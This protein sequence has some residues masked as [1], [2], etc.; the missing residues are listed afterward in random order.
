MRKILALTRGDVKNISRDP[1]LILSILGPLLLGLV[2]RFGLP[3]AADILRAET[4]FELTEHYDFIVSFLLLFTPMMLGILAGF[5]ILDERDDQILAYYAV[6]PL[7]KTGYFIYRTTAP[8]LMGFFFSF[9]LLALIPQVELNFLLLIPAILMASLQAPIFTLLLG[10][11]AENKVEGMALSKGLGII[12]LTPVVG[13]LVD[14]NWQLLA[15]VFPPYW[16]S[17]AFLASLGG[18]GYWFY[19]GA[20]ILVHLFFLVVL[21]RKFSRRAN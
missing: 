3:L 21:L 11:F 6:T 1:L 19:V 18:E 16:V 14:S 10:S 4:G 15:G 8:F 20:G 2:M 13:Y 9:L 7:T 17:K 5:V 12:F